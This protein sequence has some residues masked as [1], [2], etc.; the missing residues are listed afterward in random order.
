MKRSSEKY[1][2]ENVANSLRN[3]L[4]K[5]KLDL[6]E[7]LD[8]R[9]LDN[10]TVDEVYVLAKTLPTVQKNSQSVLYQNLLEELL[11]LGKVNPQ[12]SFRF[13]RTSTFRFKY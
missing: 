10:L 6:S 8:G 3:Q 7:F 5:L 13:I 12:E 9:K 2:R 1:N 4:K 11:E